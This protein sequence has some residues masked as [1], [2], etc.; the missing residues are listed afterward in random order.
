MCFWLSLEAEIT[1]LVLEI[2][3]CQKR[4]YFLS[5]GVVVPATSVSVFSR[6]SVC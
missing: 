5:L 2:L 1:E 6:W 4:V 3:V